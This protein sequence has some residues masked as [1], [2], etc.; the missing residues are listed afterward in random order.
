M[1]QCV[2]HYVCGSIHFKLVQCPTHQPSA[3]Q[4]TKLNIAGTTSRSCHTWGFRIIAPHSPNPRG[5][6]WAGSTLSYSRTLDWRLLWAGPWLVTQWERYIFYQILPQDVILSQYNP[7][8][9]L[10]TSVC[11]NNF[12]IFPTWTFPVVTVENFSVSNFYMNTLFHCTCLLPNEPVSIIFLW[13][14]E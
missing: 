13:S 12:N 5:V 7:L 11:E 8:C 2:I 9:I 10:I 4:N 14:T 6:P 3:G 1:K